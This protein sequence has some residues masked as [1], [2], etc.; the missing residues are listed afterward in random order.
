MIQVRGLLLQRTSP[1]YIQ[2]LRGHQTIP[3]LLSKGNALA[4]QLASSV[5]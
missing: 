2:H 5:T 3:S 1:L 4:D